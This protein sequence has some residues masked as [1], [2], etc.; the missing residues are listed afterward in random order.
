METVQLLPY[1]NLGAVKWERLGRPGPALEAIPPT[2]E[3]MKELKQ[4]LEEMGVR[5]VI[6]H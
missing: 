5:N 1:H 2:E 4:V 3:R 6:I